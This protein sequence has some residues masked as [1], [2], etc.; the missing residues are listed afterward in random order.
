MLKKTNVMLALTLLLMTL[1]LSAPAFASNQPVG[2]DV[3]INACS[4]WIVTY[5]YECRNNDT[6]KITKYTRYCGDKIESYIVE[7]L[8]L[9]GTCSSF[10]P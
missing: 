7:E 6:W 5:H 3:T 10:S 2:D 4:N 9:P 8:Y 1:L